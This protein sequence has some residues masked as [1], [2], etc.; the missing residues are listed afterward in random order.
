MQ[1]EIDKT[2][3]GAIKLTRVSY[4]NIQL[5]KLRAYERNREI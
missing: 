1:Y 3:R 2:F 4:K 5:K